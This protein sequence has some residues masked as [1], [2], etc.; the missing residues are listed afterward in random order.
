MTAVSRNGHLID[1]ISAL[2]KFGLSGRELIVTALRPILTGFAKRLASLP[3]SSGRA[4]R[5]RFFGVGDEVVERFVGVV[6][7]PGAEASTVENPV[8]S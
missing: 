1:F 6:G 2:L 4:D 5:C 7:F 3:G 8:T